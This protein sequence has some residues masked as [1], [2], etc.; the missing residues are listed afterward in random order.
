[1]GLRVRHAYL[2]VQAF[3]TWHARFPTFRQL[4]NVGSAS[5][6][7]PSF[8][9]ETFFIPEADVRAELQGQNN[10]SVPS[11][12]TDYSCAQFK[13][14]THT[15]TRREHYKCMGIA[16]ACCRYDEQARFES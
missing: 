3:G 10:A 1:M 4:R 12:Y 5:V 15:G 2:L 16:A 11:A 6:G 14:A 9:P 8:M 7:L 13:A